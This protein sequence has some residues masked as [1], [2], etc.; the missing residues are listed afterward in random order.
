MKDQQLSTKTTLNFWK[1][2]SNDGISETLSNGLPVKIRQFP[3]HQFLLNGK[4]P[5][6]LQEIALRVYNQG[7]PA[8]ADQTNVDNIKFVDYIIAYSLVEPKAYH[9]G[10]DKPDPDA[11]PVHNIPVAD[12]LEIFRKAMGTIDLSA[13]KLAPFC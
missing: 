10:I 3:L 12:R 1:T 2:F 5:N 8:I 11:I 13:E 7:T 6:K 4:L 9:P